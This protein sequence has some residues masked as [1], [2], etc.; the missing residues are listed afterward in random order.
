VSDFQCP[1]CRR[2]AEP[3][4]AISKEL[5][6]DVVIYFIQN[7]LK[8][9]RRAMDAALASNA[10]AQ[11]GKFWPYHDLLFAEQRRLSDQDLLRHARTLGLDLDRF[12]RDRRDGGHRTRIAKQAALSSELGAR[13]TPAFFITGRKSVGWGSKMGL[14][15]QLRRE[16]QATKR[17]MAAGATYRD[18]YNQRVRSNSEKPAVFLKHFGR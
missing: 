8:M 5:G 16:I 1:V 18:A 7:P 13:G 10:A 4:E 9:H 11:Q 3:M 2:A 15:S 14:V 17:L 6:G 12:E